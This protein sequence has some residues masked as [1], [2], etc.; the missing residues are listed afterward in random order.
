MKL[1]LK[2]VGFIVT[3][4]VVLVL[5]AMMIVPPIAKN[6]INQHGKDLMGRQVFVDNLSV[7]LFSGSCSLDSLIIFEADGQQ[8]FVQL[9]HLYTNVE[10]LQLLTGV[11]DLKTLDFEHLYVSVE[12]NDTIFNFSDIIDFFASDEIEPKD[13]TSIGIPV[14]IEDINIYNSFVRYQ[15]LV[16]GSDFQL[17]D[18]SVSIPGIDLRRLNTKVGLD[19]DFVNGGKLSLALNYDDFTSNYNIDFN[20]VEFNLHTIYPYIYQSIETPDV[21]GSLDAHFNVYGNLKHVLDFNAE[22]YTNVH[23]FVLYDQTNTSCMTCDSLSIGTANIRLLQNS[24]GFSHIIANHPH[25]SIVISSDSIDNLSRMLAVDSIPAD[26]EPQQD[27]AHA[28]GIE[29]LQITIDKIAINDAEVTFIDST[30]VYEPFTYKIN[31]GYLNAENFDLSGINNID[32]TAQPG[33]E[34]G[35]ITAHYKGQ[36]NDFHNMLINVKVNQVSL[37]DFSPYTL[38][39]FGTPL[40][41]GLLTFETDTNVESGNLSSKNHLIIDQP[42][43][44]KRNKDIK[45]ELNVPFKTGVYLLTDIN[46]RLDIELPVSGNIDEPKFSYKKLLFK[47]F[48]KMIVKVVASPFRRKLIIPDSLNYA[49]DSL[50]RQ[51]YIDSLRWAN[52]PLDSI[53]LDNFQN[54]SI[55][56]ILFQQ[57]FD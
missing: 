27:S 44:E 53:S 4:L 36:F 14:V 38:H 34:K 30:L 41:N 1:A 50:C 43:V 28:I 3:I 56:N 37:K 35:T 9:G 54:D 22:G 49:S 23:N 24:Y 32:F 29:P 25:V 11:I 55:T 13:T 39:M 10:I 17:A 51:R 45:P 40:T 52:M 2:F 6:Y 20:L 57:E 46:N 15:D 16:V 5:L 42:V 26:T 7:N 21:Q 47:T 8:P 18:F 33:S 19:L 31:H 48:G 12:Q